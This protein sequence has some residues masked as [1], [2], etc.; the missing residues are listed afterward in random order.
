MGGHGR[1]DTKAGCVT[2]RRIK[3]TGQKRALTRSVTR[4]VLRGYLKEGFFLLAHEVTW[5]GSNTITLCA[6]SLSA[7][8]AWVSAVGVAHVCT[9]AVGSMKPSQLRRPQNKNNGYLDI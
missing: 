7:R 1:G 9:G 5:C 8:A 6:R 3:K 4:A 2:S